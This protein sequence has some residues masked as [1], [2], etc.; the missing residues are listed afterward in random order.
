MWARLSEDA[1]LLLPPSPMRDVLR[2]MRERQEEVGEPWPS[3]PLLCLRLMEREVT[4]GGAAE[5][6]M[7]ECGLRAV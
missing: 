6:P 1:A 3:P 2:E 5:A 7:W 4:G